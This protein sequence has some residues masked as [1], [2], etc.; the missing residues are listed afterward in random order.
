MSNM[1]TY[2][3]PQPPLLKRETTSQV[4]DNVVEPTSQVCDNVLTKQCIQCSNLFISQ[5]DEQWK[6][7]CVDCY[8]AKVRQCTSCQRNIRIDAEEWKKQCTTCWLDKRKQ[9]FGTCP[10]CPENK[11]AHLRRKLSDPACSE[12]MQQVYSS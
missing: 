9:L 4:F 6:T 1:A 12:C 5:L 3:F 2:Y 7:H 10:T 11:K 8:R